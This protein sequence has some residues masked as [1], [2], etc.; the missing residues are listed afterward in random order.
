MSDSTGDLSRRDALRHLG[1]GVTATGAGMVSLEAAQHAH[2][3]VAQQKSAAKGEYAPK[4][5]TA[6]EYQTLRRLADLIM[7]GSLDAGAP[8]FIDYLSSQN[9]EMGEIYTGGIFWID[10]E[11]KRRHG[12]TFVDAKPADQTALLDLI[13]SRRNATPELA[14]GIHFFAWMRNMVVDAYYTSPVGVKDLGY[15]GNQAVSEFSVPAEALAYALKRS[16]FA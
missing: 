11:M 2:E 5:F 14:P 8:E 16:P 15:M 12:A 13:A 3:T 1:I 10:T 9:K 7:P 4:Y 6:H